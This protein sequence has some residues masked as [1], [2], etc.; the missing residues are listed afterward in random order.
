MKFPGHT[1]CMVFRGHYL[2]SST[3]VHLFLQCFCHL[4]HH[5]SWDLGIWI[6]IYTY[7]SSW[8]EYTTDTY[9]LY[10]DFFLSFFFILFNL[11]LTLQILSPSQ[12]TLWLFHIHYLIVP[13]TVS[14]RMYP[15]PTTTYPTRLSTTWGLQTLKGYMNLSDWTSAETVLGASYQMEYAASSFSGF[16]GTMLIETAGPPTGFLS[17][18]ASSRFSLIQPQESVASDLWMVQ[19]SA[20][21]SAAC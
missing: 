10:F 7:I 1:F 21:L 8:L 3:L 2:A 4:F 9:W 14:T 20:S 6:A 18:S 11:F 17:S 16:W 19:I 12:F 13:P 5:V 15:P